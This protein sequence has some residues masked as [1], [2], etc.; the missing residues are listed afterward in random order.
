MLKV[1]YYFLQFRI[2]F[3]LVALLV[4]GSCVFIAGRV[5]RRGA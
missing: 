2:D 4:A 5:R 1:L 3:V